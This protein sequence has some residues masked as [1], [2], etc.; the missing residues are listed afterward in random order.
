MPGEESGAPEPNSPEVRRTLIEPS[1]TESSEVLSDPA[2]FMPPPPP[3][4]PKAKGLNRVVKKLDSI[5]L[6][7]RLDPDAC[8]KIAEGSST[9]KVAQLKELIESAS[10]EPLAPLKLID[11]YRQTTPCSSRWDDMNGKGLFKV[12]HKCRLHVYDFSKTDRLDA[13]KL[14]LQR[15]GKENPSF[16]RR[17]DGKFLTAD[18]PVAV[19][20]RRNLVIASAAAALIIIAVVTLAVLAPPA[21]PPAVTVSPTTSS[22]SQSSTEVKADSASQSRTPSQLKRSSSASSEV[23]MPYEQMIMGGQ[24]AAPEQPAWQDQQQN[25]PPNPYFDQSQTRIQQPAEVTTGALKAPGAPGANGFTAPVTP[26]PAATSLP[27]ITPTQTSPA[28]TPVQE[29]APA[30]REQ[31]NSNKGSERTSSPYIQYYK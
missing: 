20:Q 6:K 21:P 22:D 17:K 26:A 9:K 7:T 16:Y 13:E 10:A 24:Q 11:K 18:C 1:F 4:P 14:V 5:C 19:A 12:C 2:G 29:T 28:M 8:R 15:E 31:E 25:A 27:Q 3:P 30:A 23:I